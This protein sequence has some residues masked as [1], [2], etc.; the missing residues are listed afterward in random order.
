M[1]PQS[2]LLQRQ[3]T[4]SIVLVTFLTLS[5]C[6][7]CQTTPFS[8]LNLQAEPDRKPIAAH[9]EEL[10]EP[11]IASGDL[12]KVGILGAADS[13]QELRVSAGG[14]ISLQLVGPVHVAQLTAR[15]AELLIEQRLSAGGFFTEPHVSVFIK[16]YATQGVSIFGEVQRP[17]VYPLLGVHRLLDVLSVA[18]GMT[19]KAGRAVTVT[20]KTDPQHPVHLIMPKDPA[21]FENTIEILP[22]DTVIVSRAGVVYV[23]GGVRRPMAI[24]MERDSDMTVLQAIAMAEGTTPE[25]GLNSAKLIR[26]SD[27]QPH[28][29]PINLKKV[30]A[31]KASDIKLQ[32]ED[33]VFVP[34][35]AYRNLARRSMETVVQ[36]TTGLVIYRRY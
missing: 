27:G 13:D 34:N 4:F 8:A 23:V 2:M 7:Y 32:D 33:I 5:Q 17:G 18:G 24:V 10:G 6:G 29:L 14:D 36:M 35:S 3:L 25:A 11:L 20:H 22:G 19:P 12:L 9:Q 16:E 1:K 26:R 30:L 21:K 31:A 15:Q 28:E